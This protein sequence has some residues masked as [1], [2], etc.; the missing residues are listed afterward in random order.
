MIPNILS[1][2]IFAPI[3]LAFLILFM[4]KENETMIKWYAMIVSLIPF[5]LSLVLF[6]TYDPANPEYQFV[7]K[8][9]WITALN[10]YYYLGIDGISMLLIVLSTF[11]M[12]LCILASWNTI[13]VRIKE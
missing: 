3:V 2:T 10:S 8:W 1:L 9:K 7:E 13:K 5:V 12:P 4:K 6:F 11:I